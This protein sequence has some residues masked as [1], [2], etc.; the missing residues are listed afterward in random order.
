M[1]LDQL[2]TSSFASSALFLFP[3]F[4]FFFK[5]T[6]VDFSIVNN[7]LVH[8]LQTHK[9]YFSTIFF[10]KNGS[11]GI[12]YTIFLVFNFQFQQNKCYRNKL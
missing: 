8:G 2:I 7:A 11:H 10:I 9:F 12:I 6:L 1:C 5:P 4:F 3:F